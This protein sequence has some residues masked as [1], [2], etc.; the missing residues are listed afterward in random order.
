TELDELLLRMTDTDWLTLMMQ[1]G[2]NP[3]LARELLGADV[4]EENFVERMTAIKDL[5]SHK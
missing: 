4:T 5:R 1:V 2:T 3:A